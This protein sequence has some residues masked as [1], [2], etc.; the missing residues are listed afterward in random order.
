MAAID[1]IIFIGDFME[2]FGD[3]VILCGGK[4]RRMGFDKALMKIGEDY[5]IDIATKKLLQIFKN[6]SLSVNGSDSD[7]F[8]H[9]GINIVEDIF[10]DDI[11][12]AA[13]VHAAL[14][15]AKSKYVFVIAVDMPLL[16]IQHISH[17][18]S[19]V[20]RHVPD[21][22]IPINAGFTEPLYAFYSVDAV[23]IL[24]KEIREGEYGLP[25]IFPKFNTYY[26]KESESLRFDSKLAMF[27]NLN[28][29]ED[30]STISLFAKNSLPAPESK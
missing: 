26:M 11:G 2:H 7:K 10:K 9:F 22:L 28:F 15:S 20:Q 29:V 21:A 3:A 17:M 8:L 6:V 18:R 24:E 23:D 16:N 25:K 14:S 19:L 4:S 12:P 27:T 1:L 13:A 30:L 5:A